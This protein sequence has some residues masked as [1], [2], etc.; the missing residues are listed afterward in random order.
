MGQKKVNDFLLAKYKK[1]KNTAFLVAWLRILLK[2][3][4]HVEKKLTFIF[5]TTI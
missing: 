3:L 5:V 2:N 4:A 1:L